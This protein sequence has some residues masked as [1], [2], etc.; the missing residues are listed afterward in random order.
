ML[1]SERSPRSAKFGDHPVT[2]GDS[3]RI[4]VSLVYSPA[5]SRTGPSRPDGSSGVSFVNLLT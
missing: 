1:I 3:R 2:N 4:R 5:I